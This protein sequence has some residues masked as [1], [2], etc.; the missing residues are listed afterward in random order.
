[1]FDT[2][3]PPVAFLV[4]FNMEIGLDFVAQVVYEI[5]L[6]STEIVGVNHSSV[7][8]MLMICCW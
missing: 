1:M 7:F 8:L 4:L 6:L 5:C 3:W 2:Q